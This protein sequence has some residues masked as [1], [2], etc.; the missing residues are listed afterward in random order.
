M[1]DEWC[2]SAANAATDKLRKERREL[3]IP[4]A[5][6]ERSLYGSEFEIS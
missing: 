1:S 4:K 3:H 2:F 5:E 6:R